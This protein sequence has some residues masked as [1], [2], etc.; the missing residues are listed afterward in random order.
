[1][2]AEET[3]TVVAYYNEALLMQRNS[4]KLISYEINN[5]RPI[6]NIYKADK[7]FWNNLY[8]Q[9]NP[10]FYSACV[11]LSLYKD[12]NPCHHAHL[13]VTDYKK[14]NLY[15]FVASFFPDSYL[16]YYYNRLY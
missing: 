12:L 6:Y 15:L 11:N 8:P 4:S 9:R 1:M 5:S 14:W 13:S 16:Q 2:R 10:V 3:I 7:M